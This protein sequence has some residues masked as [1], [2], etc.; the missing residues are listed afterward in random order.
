MKASPQG[1]GFYEVS[2]QILRDPNLRCSDFRNRNLGA[3]S[4]K[5]PSA[6]DYTLVPVCWAPYT[7]DSKVVLSLLLWSFAEIFMDS[8]RQIIFQ[9]VYN[10]I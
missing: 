9:I 10:F 6:I 5:Q 8:G 7:N 2:V 3:T 4:W 1:P